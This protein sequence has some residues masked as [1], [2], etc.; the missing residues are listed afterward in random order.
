MLKFQVMAAASLAVG[1]SLIATPASGVYTLSAM[2]AGASS[3]SLAPGDS[4]VLAVSLAGDIDDVHTSAIFR[5]VFSASGLTLLGYS[6]SAPYI[7][8]GVFDD[9]TPSAASLPLFLT[10]ETLQGTGYPSDTID[11]E[12][13]NV[14][15]NATS[16]PPIF[17]T[18]TLL[19]MMLRLDGNF[20]NLPNE[21]TIDLVPDTFANGFEPV[22]VMTGEAFEI[23]VVP[24][25]ASVLLALAAAVAMPRR[26]RS[27]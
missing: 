18:G 1:V 14:T 21:I 8:G 24:A 17:S 9:S 13:S 20:E 15:G 10:A 25:P 7:T 5:T 11:I 12:F 23:V 2:S 3:V 22:E 16:P 4:F 6:W 26:R 19:T 27:N